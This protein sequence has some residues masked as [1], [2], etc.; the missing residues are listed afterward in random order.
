M[1]LIQFRP[2]KVRRV[3]ESDFITSSNPAN[4]EFAKEDLAKSGLT[5]EDIWGTAPGNL[6][7]VDGALAG[8]YI[9]YFDINGEILRDASN[10]NTMYRVKLKFSTYAKNIR[11]TQPSADELQSYEL[12]SYLPYLYP[13][14]NLTGDT[15]YCAEGEKKTASV[16][17]NLGLPAFGISGCQ[18]W[19]NPTKR[20]GPHPW[21]IEY[22][23]RRGF[24][25]VVIIPDTD[26]FRY[27]ICTAYGTFA[28]ALTQAGFEVQ[29]LNPPDKIDDLIVR[30]GPT[31][32]DQFAALQ[33]IDPAG[34]VQTAASLASTYN[35]AFKYD[36][37]GKTVVHQHTSNIMRLL[38]QHPAF[39]KIWLN[40]DTNKIMLG[41]EE[42][43]P[44]FTEM[45]LANHMQHNFNMEKVHNRVL[46]DCIK[47]LSRENERSPFLEYI[48]GLVWDGVKR[49]DTWLRDYWG[50]IDNTFN[51]EVAAKW[52]VSACARMAVPGTKVDWMFICIGPQGT[53]KTSMPA[54]L[55]KGNNATLYGEHDNKDL[56]LLL[57]S[58]LCI[59][60]DE[61]DTFSKKDNSLLKAMITTTEDMFRP[62]Y[63]ATIES[64]KR[65]FTLYG[66]G[67]RH[68]F[69]QNDPTGQRRYAIVEVP[70]LLD[71][72]GLEQIRDQLWA[73]A[74]SVYQ[75]GT[76]KFWEVDGA[77]E[78][79]KKY[80][81]PSPLRE[82]IEAFINNWTPSKIAE[83]ALPGFTMT[84]MLSSGLFANVNG[85]SQA[86]IREAVGILREFGWIRKVVKSKGRTIGLYTLKK[87]D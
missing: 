84:E 48:Q 68:E 10:F 15:V 70:R 1:N 12:P 18:A 54:I 64:F 43:V 66:C 59:G 81:I 47:S 5:L 82:K 25:K 36:A 53:G 63:G 72:K 14:E 7:L 17:R 21:I 11:Y 16:V 29:L 37:K 57:H 26:I 4:L 55:F 27:D 24:K 75:D 74:W 83:V 44:D 34:L 42:S 51:R 78:N 32:R 86:V 60:F 33:P 35:L 62:P 80:E 79:A 2:Y 85:E 41:N 39:P 61:L 9:P 31:A 40:R 49:L 20:G 30:W 38:R 67:N 73:E 65:R 58:A 3:I 13:C 50:V 45:E 76:V 6:K 87:E 71:F 22:L 46:R 28:H 56:C 77:S 8:Y 23:N 69:L 52:L 19:G